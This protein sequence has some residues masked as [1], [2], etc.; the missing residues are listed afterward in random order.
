IDGMRRSKYRIR[1]AL[2]D[3]PGVKLRRIIDTDGDTGAFLITTY[4]DS[5]TAKAVNQALR[6]EGIVTSPQGLSNI[7]MTDWGLHLYYNIV[8]LLDMRSVDANGFP[9]KLSENAGLQKQYRKGAC[10]FAD[11]VFERSI[12]MSIPSCL[13]N[14]DEDDIIQA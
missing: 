2:K 9:W 7:M 4:D 8:S 3:L 10:P 11:S 6:A 5:T 12:I 1:Q 13:T 14:R